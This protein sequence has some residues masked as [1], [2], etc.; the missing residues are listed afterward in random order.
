M[1]LALFGPGWML[2]VI[3]LAA[4]GVGIYLVGR[5]RTEEGKRRLLAI[6][7]IAVM[8]S[9]VAFHVAYLTDPSVH[10]PLWQNLPLHLCT[11]ASF[12]L[13]PALIAKHEFIR[14][15]LQ[16]FVFFPGALAGLLAL[17]SAAPFYFEAP[18]FSAKA[19]FFVAHGMNFVVPVLMVAFGLYSPTVKDSLKAPLVL[20]VIS[21][22]ILPITLLLRA[23]LDPAA[24]YMFVFDPEGAEILEMFYRLVPVP[25]L[26][27]T[28]ML[29]FFTPFF[30]VQWL[31][32]TGLPKVPALLRRRL[33]SPE[34]VA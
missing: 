29:A 34:P 11:L 8:A 3:A 19:L 13:L 24:N 2:M 28:L 7:S 23:T 22:A 9:S 6:V 25:I 18:L 20:A 33:P 32:A 10:F 27:S 21:F 17:V 15:N 31:A 12:L 16:I 4:A 26:Y 1:D 30:V 14:K 5:N